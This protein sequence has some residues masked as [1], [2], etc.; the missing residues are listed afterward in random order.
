MRFQNPRKGISVPCS[1]RR[2]G[3]ISRA[4]VPQEIT[5]KRMM[6]LILRV[7]RDLVRRDE[8]V[9]AKSRAAVVLVL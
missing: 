9:T 3:L 5:L 8:V 7:P 6:T 4:L 1:S 2:L